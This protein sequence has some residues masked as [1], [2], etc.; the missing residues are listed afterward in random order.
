MSKTRSRLRAVAHRSHSEEYADSA[1]IN[2][3]IK[4]DLFIVICQKQITG[5]CWPR[6]NSLQLR[7]RSHCQYLT[8]DIDKLLISFICLSVCPS[9]RPMLCFPLDIVSKR[10]YISSNFILSGRSIIL[11]FV[12]QTP[13]L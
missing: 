9:V 2:Q 5:A 7:L 8:S 3:L 1:A 6:L 10:L 4:I 12:A 13:L 11:T